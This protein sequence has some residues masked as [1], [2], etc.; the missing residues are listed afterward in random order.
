[1]SA[2]APDH[3]ETL[4][5][6]CL[7]PPEQVR[8]AY[9]RQAQRYHPDRAPDDPG[10]QQMMARINEAYTVLSDPARR[11]SYDRW[12]E[13]RKARIE[14][15]HAA[16]LAADVSGFE[17]AWPWYLLCATI[18][19]AL[20]SVA[21]VLYKAAVPSVAPTAKTVTQAASR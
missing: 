7:A 11:A 14:A 21:T 12:I 5:V 15:E 17:N 18:A 8:L 6:P 10:A 13:A 19:F 2:T 3:Y 16:R 20:L 1:M 4:S 9:R